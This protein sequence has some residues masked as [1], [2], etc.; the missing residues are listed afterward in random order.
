MIKLLLHVA[1][2]IL[3]SQGIA[4]KTAV[5]SVK[6]LIPAGVQVTLTKGSNTVAGKKIDYTTQ[7]GYLDLKN[8]TG[9]LV[10]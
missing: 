8:D 1:F 3:C 2:V 6:D 7:T 9:K 5:I 4:Q 10:A